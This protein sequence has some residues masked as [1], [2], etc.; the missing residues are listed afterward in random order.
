MLFAADSAWLDTRPLDLAARGRERLLGF[1]GQ[2]RAA[3][4]A[5]FGTTDD[6]VLKDPRIC[7]MIPFYRNLLGGMG[8]AV[9]VVIALRQPADV[10]AS[11]FTR[12]QIS[13]DYT[14]F[15]W[16]RHLLEAERETR[17]LPRIVVPY[18]ALIDDWR[19]MAHRLQGFIGA[20]SAPVD[21]GRLDSPVRRDL[22]HHRFNSYE[23]F[24]GPLGELLRDL[25]DA[26]SAHGTGN[27]ADTRFSFDQMAER[28]STASA[29]F[30][31]ELTAEFC[32]QR[33]T[34]PYDMVAAPDPLR[35]RRTLAEALGRL[36]RSRWSALID[37]AAK[38]RGEWE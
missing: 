28:L 2:L 7:R 11:L 32:F 36:H 37:Y 16:A 33:L 30:A 31:D 12:N 23:A 34:S 38:Q 14:G 1:D 27:A 13:P 22:H 26:L 24:S 35:E 5:S 10:A 20:G 29:A 8:I 15:L 25:H 18:E 6:F 17:D 21:P 19:A 9:K 4:D 3:L